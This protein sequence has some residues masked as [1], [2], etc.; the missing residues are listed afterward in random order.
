M[1]AAS[2]T[3]RASLQ[4]RCTFP[5]RG[6]SRQF[7]CSTVGREQLEILLILLPAD[8][9]GVSIRNAGEPFTVFVLTLDFLLAVDSSAIPPTSVGVGASVSWVVQHAL[10]CGHGQRSE[11]H[12]VTHA[13]PRWESKALLAKHL[14][15]LAR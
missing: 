1:S 4:Q 2:T 6:R 3:H 10:G 14:H 7:V 11:H 9:A 13:Q 5:R 15:C 12:G 8:V